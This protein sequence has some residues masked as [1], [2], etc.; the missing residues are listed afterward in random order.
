MRSRFSVRMPIPS[1]F[2]ARFFR[3]SRGKGPFGI[4]FLC[5]LFAFAMPPAAQA[6]LTKL[7]AGGYTD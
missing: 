1:P 4:A 3:V 7:R 6:L 5:L 2:L